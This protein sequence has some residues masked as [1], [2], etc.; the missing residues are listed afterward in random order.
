MKKPKIDEI[1]GH[2]NNGPKTLA[3]KSEIASHLYI[4]LIKLI[5]YT[6]LT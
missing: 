5:V 3:G 1:L 6:S 4:S 2:Y